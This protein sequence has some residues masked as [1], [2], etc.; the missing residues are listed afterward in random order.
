MVLFA[1]QVNNDGNSVFDDNDNDGDNDRTFYR[2]LESAK[3][4]K[5]GGSLP[6][7]QLEASALSAK[8]EFLQA[9]KEARQEFKEAKQKQVLEFRRG[10]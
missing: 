1:Q 7:E 8:E 6:K 9:M 3:R 4:S 10:G 5:L 2:D